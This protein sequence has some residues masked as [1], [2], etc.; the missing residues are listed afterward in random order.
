VKLTLLGTGAPL[1]PTRATLGMLLEAPG[2]TPLL[3]DSCGGFEIARRLHRN[4]T[5]FADLGDVLLSHRHGDHIGGVMALA[6]AV[7]PLR[8]HG[9]ADTL[10]TTEAL[11]RLC[12][13]HVT[14]PATRRRTLHPLAGGE[15]SRIAG[16]EIEAIEV[17]HRVPTLA[18]RIAHG[19]AVLA[20]SADSLPCDALVTVAK[21]VDLFVCDALCADSNL[22]DSAHALMHPTAGDAARIA[23]KAGAKRLALV[24]LA[25]Y[26]DEG[27]MLTEARA[28]FGGEVLIPDDGDTLEIVATP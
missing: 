19:D 1:S 25:R 10:D 23:A 15:R 14:D 2:C 8:L 13:P 26:A 24:H 17:E 3:I 28:H 22:P 18:L 9:S 27:A 11:L 16:F 5:P 12:Y 21:G 4:G 20:Y 7:S 6:L